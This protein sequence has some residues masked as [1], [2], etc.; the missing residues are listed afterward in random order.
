MKIPQRWVGAGALIVVV[1][2]SA[3]LLSDQSDR[4][5]TGAGTR[6]W[7]S[8]GESRD[9]QSR[10]IEDLPTSSARCFR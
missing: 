5:A 10:Q 6:W 3:W 4:A 1:G 8:R 9:E 7:F 2:S